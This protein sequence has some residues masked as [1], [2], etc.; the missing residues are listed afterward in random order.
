MEFIFLIK[1]AS[2]MTNNVDSQSYPLTTCTIQSPLRLSFISRGNWNINRKLKH[3]YI[4]VCPSVG[5]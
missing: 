4:H 3:V 1:I 5:R 2:V